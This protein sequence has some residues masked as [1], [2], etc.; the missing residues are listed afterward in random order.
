M[1]FAVNVEIVEHPVQDDL[2]LTALEILNP[3]IGRFPGN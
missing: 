3:V 2:I 1:V